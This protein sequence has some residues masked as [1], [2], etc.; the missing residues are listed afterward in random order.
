MFVSLSVLY[1]FGPCRSQYNQT[2]QGALFHPEDGL[3]LL[4]FQ[5]ESIFRTTL[6][7]LY[8]ETEPVSANVI[9]KRVL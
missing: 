9:K 6:R 7:I 5:K 8:D 1:E 2:L 3:Q 4:L